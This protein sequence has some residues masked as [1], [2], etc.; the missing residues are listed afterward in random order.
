M[1]ITH[2]A[3]SE[4]LIVTESGYR[5]VT[6]P[7]DASCGYLV[8]KI[9][10]DTVLVSH[11]HHDHDAV[12]LIEGEPT[13]IDY[14]GVRTITPDIRLT[15]IAGWH[16]DAHGAKR[17]GN[18]MF[19]LEAE[20]LRIAHLGDIGCMPEESDL[21][22]LKGL[23]LL[24]IPVGGFFT[25]DAGKAKEL[26]RRICPKT[27]IPMHYRTEYNAQWPIAPVDDFLKLTDGD[28]EHV[29]QIRVT[30]EDVD[31]LPDTIVLKEPECDM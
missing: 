11:H 9:A 25:I 2:I 10:A 29:A 15:A 26:I 7:C 30:A 22:M 6:D 8:R 3:H 18:L 5:I 13:V 1:L 27:V 12:D 24:M 16:D 14:A 31:C 4:F 19:I 17:G 28:Y 20:G 23:D 21:E